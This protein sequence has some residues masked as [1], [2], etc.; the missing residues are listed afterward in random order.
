MVFS[1]WLGTDSQFGPAL[2]LAS[3]AAS[4]PSWRLSLYA[5]LAHAAE[6]AFPTVSAPTAHIP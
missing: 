5:Q 2:D 1:L 6:Q 4:D 3:I